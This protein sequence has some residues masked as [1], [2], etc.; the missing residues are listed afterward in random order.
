MDILTIILS[1][2]RRNIESTGV[3]PDALQD[4]LATVDRQMR[5]S[6]GG[7]Q[8]HISRLPQMPAKSRIIELANTGLPAAEIGERLQ[9]HP[10][11]V[12]RV[13]RMIRR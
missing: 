12:R 1:A 9:V 7:A 3:P 10:Q 8:H 4:A 13:L 2:V 11:Y 5:S 6:L